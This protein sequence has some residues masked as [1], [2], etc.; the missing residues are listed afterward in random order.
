VRVPS[1]QETP[2]VARCNTD[3]CSVADTL[4]ALQIGELLSPAYCRV[5]DG[6][7]A[8]DLH[9]HLQSLGGTGDGAVELYKF[10]I[11]VK[12]DVA[13]VDVVGQ[14]EV[15]CWTRRYRA[16]ATTDGGGERAVIEGP[17]LVEG[18]T[19]AVGASVEVPV[20][21]WSVRCY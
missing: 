19:A 8:K 7:V 17:L 14:W 4:P 11:V 6:V 12:F 15:T 1:V 18:W 10:L 13:R 3:A 5:V 16:R 2:E 9:S 20:K 21:V